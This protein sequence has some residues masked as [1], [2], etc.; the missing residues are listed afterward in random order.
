MADKKITALTAL[1]ATGKDPAADLLHI[2]YFSASPVN[3]KISVAN[4]FNN[5]NTDTHIYGASKTLEVGFAAAV[6]AHLTVTTGAN[7]ATDG[8]VT[9]NDD[10][11]NF[12]DFLVKSGDSDSAIKVDAGATPNNVTINGDSA[13]LDFVVNGDTTASMIH[14]DASA[15]AVGIGIAAPATTY[16]LDVGEV[17]SGATGKSIQCA[18]GADIGGN[19]TITGSLGVTGDTTLTGA[20]TVT[21]LPKFTQ[22]AGTT[23]VGTAA[24]ATTGVIPL[25][26][27]V[28]YL[29]VDGTTNDEFTLADGVT[30]QMKI[31]IA[32]VLANSGVAKIGIT[33]FD[34]TGSNDCLQLN[35][36]GE[37]VTLIFH[38][39][40]WYVIGH[41]GMVEAVAG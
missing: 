11:V 4:L 18:G 40:K 9:I 41:H 14:V 29:S 26:T 34:F 37:S 10:G 27:L 35:T 32:T 6:N 36:V 1:T 30:G 13:N 31:L 33:S 3:K 28:S 5:A 16:M 38:T 24:G 23:L 8:T 12:V 2:I 7:N 17:G 19:S 15:D 21:G 20:A 22:A 39:A 25:T